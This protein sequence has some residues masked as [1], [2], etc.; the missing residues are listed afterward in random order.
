MKRNFY[1]SMLIAA[2]MVLVGQTDTVFAAAPPEEQRAIPPTVIQ[3]ISALA[4]ITNP[5]PA[6]TQW[7][8]ERY[9]QRPV[10]LRVFVGHADAVYALAISPDGRHV[11]TGS[12]DRT[13]RIWDIQK[14][15]QER[16]LAGHASAVNGVAISPDGKHVVTVSDITARIWDM[17]PVSILINLNLK[18]V[19]VLQYIHEKVLAGEKLNLAREAPAVVDA[20]NAYNVLPELIK[21]LVREFVILPR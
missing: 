10:P 6:V 15:V 1:F 7:L 16:E 5:L 2:L 20:R 19:R 21:E 18:Q 12:A 4:L 14:G 17:P 9:C 3:E 13:A 8:L 11:V